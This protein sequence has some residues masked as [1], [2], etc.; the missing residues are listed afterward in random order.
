MA[1]RLK[2]M[3][4]YEACCFAS[5]A[6]ALKCTR[7]GAQQGIPGFGEVLEFMKTHKGVVRDG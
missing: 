3:D 5:A 2:G 7:F 1:A 6:S 4:V